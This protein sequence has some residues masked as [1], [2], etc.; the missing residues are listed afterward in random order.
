LTI[1]SLDL[2]RR[3]LFTKSLLKVAY[4]SKSCCTLSCSL[5]TVA[6]SFEILFSVVEA[7]IEVDDSLFKI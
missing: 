5:A 3:G 7:L 4:S 1:L 2:E 6:S